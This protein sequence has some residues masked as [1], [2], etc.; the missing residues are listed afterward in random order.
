MLDNFDDIRPFRD[1]EINDAMKRICAH[2][3]FDTLS[4]YVFPGISPAIIRSEMLSF[5]TINEFQ[6]S[7][8]TKVN[9][10]IIKAGIS[11]FTYSGIENISQ[12]KSYL[13]VSNHRDIMLDSSLLQYV[14]HCNGLKTT[15]ITFGANL[16]CDPLI[17]DIG[18]SNKMFRVERSGSMKDFYRSSRR[19]S[20]YI[21]HTI[22]QNNES[23]WIAQRNGRTKDGLDKTE[24]G[25]IR[26]F[27]A[28]GDDKINALKD[29]NIVPISISYEW[30]PCDFEK[31]ME[32]LI[33]RDSQYV[34]QP[35][36]DIR[37][38][39]NGILR[40]KGKVNIN[41]CKPLSNSDLNKLEGLSEKELYKHVATLIDSRIDAGYKLYPNNYIAADILKSSTN[42][43]NRYSQDD[44]SIFERHL[45]TIQ[46]N[47]GI[48]SSELREIILR[49][50][51]TPVLK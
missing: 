45:Y 3:L 38:I 1:N 10:R 26:M 28:V 36:E 43:T 25:L 35:G 49:I 22:T 2:P 12:D 39:V 37:S 8:M 21:F 32:L 4:E 44:K 24:P 17:I 11:E 27:A 9:E 50:Y 19:L 40:Y 23:V 15:E 47:G 41:I 13:F 20:E 46:V 30:E 48:Y 34:K 42:F 5:N 51:A 29:L 33:S 14:L 7:I 18:K 16:M 6:S 31:G